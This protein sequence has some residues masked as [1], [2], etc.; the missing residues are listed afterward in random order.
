MKKLPYLLCLLLLAFT[1][2]GHAWT[3]EENFDDGSFDPPWRYKD[4]WKDYCFQEPMPQLGCPSNANVVVYDTAEKMAG[5]YSL[6]CVYNTW[7]AAT[8]VLFAEDYGRENFGSNYYYRAYFKWD[9]SYK[10]HYRTKLIEY[11]LGSIT[12]VSGS[13]YINVN[14]TYC[15]EGI[16]WIGWWSGEDTS[17]QCATIMIFSE[18]AYNSGYRSGWVASVYDEMGGNSDWNVKAG[19]G[20]YYIEAHV[21]TNTERFDL[22]MQRPGDASPT[23]V[24]SNVDLRM[25][26]AAGRT[27]SYMDFGW[28]NDTEEGAGGTMWI[29]E[30]KIS[31]AYIGPISG[32]STPSI[33]TGVSV[34]GGSFH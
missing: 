14:A 26:A 7:G 13:T 5:T 33:M 12:S 31:D 34:T 6:K 3:V 29:D 30:I 24:L 9:D 2:V 32:D 16:T 11:N 22:W 4:T 19:E 18:D 15:D 27:C 21:N 17:S 8:V 20:W 25:T 10:F 23:Q 28:L 1:S